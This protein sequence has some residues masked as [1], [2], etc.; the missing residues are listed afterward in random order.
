MRPKYAV[1]SISYPA[2]IIL[3]RKLAS[4][5]IINLLRYSSRPFFI[6]K[7]LLFTSAFIL[8]INNIT[9]YRLVINNSL[10]NSTNLK[11]SSGLLIKF[12]VGLSASFWIPGV[13]NSLVL[14][15]SFFFFLIFL[16]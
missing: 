13:S 9:D 10:I 16:I 1:I 15:F 12:S 7:L 14:L 11:S 4:S 5:G 3:I 2:L 8:Y 6:K